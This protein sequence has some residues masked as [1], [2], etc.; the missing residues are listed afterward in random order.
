MESREREKEEENCDDF[1][2]PPSVKPPY[3]TKLLVTI[4]PWIK[5]KS[6]SLNPSHWIKCFKDNHKIKSNLPKQDTY[7]ALAR[8]GE[9]KS[10]KRKNY[11]KN[12]QR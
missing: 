10:Q 2:S 11:G 3:Y 6:P 8:R 4:H 5:N 7:S 9:R 1:L 12:V